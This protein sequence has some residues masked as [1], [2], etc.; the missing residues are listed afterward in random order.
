MRSRTQSLL[1]P[2]SA[3]ANATVIETERTQAESLLLV[4]KSHLA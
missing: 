4:F 3:Q 2:E 1:V